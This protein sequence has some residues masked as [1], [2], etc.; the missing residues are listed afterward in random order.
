MR[1]PSIG[2]GANLYVPLR[3]GRKPALGGLAFGSQV[4]SGLGKIVVKIV[5][6]DHLSRGDGSGGI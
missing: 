5:G 2:S 4:K 1:R 6:M 3:V